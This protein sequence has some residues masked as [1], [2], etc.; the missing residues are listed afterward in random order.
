LARAAARLTG[1]AEM[2]T[3]FKAMVA[4]SPHLATP[5]PFGQP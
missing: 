4:T 3:L 1:E 5:Y 2:G